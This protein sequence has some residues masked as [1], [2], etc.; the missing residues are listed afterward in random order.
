MFTYSF[1][2]ADWAYCAGQTLP[3]AQNTALFAVIGSTYGG[4]YQ[5]TMDMP[6]LQGR[7]PM[8]VGGMSNT[9]PGLSTHMLSEK[10]GVASIGLTEANL[11]AHDHH[12][13]ATKTTPE[14][15]EPAKQLPAK[16]EDPDG[17]GKIF[18]DADSDLDSQFNIQA[19]GPAGGKSTG[20]AH[21]NRQPYIATPFCI[22]LYGIF[23]S[24]S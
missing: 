13:K 19:V 3:V 11:P 22:A 17:P 23:P 10:S 14:N 24:R 5:T 6:N 16:H 18:V 9:G 7:A 12:I 1:A 20:E 8:H 21:E 4:D 2:P 15:N